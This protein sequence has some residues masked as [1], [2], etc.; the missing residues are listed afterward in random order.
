MTTTKEYTKKNKQGQ[1]K[2]QE[3]SLSDSGALAIAELQLAELQSKGLCAELPETMQELA[4]SLALALRLDLSVGTPRL[5]II[6]DTRE[7]EDE[8]K[9]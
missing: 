6:I 3:A 8:A 9:N 1:E 2:S 5:F 4:K 7:K